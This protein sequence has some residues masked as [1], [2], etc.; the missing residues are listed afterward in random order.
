MT[1]ILVISNDKIFLN[2]KKVYSDYN[3][4]INVIEAI[5]NDFNILL[6]SR[7]SN[8]KNDFSAK[9]NNKISRI[10]LN[11]LFNLKK[12]KFKIFMIS[13]TPR[14]ILFYA[15]IKLF[16]KNLDGYVFLRSNGHKEYQKKI[17]KFGYIFYDIMQKYAEKNLKVISVSKKIKC[18]NINFLL[19]PSELNKTWFQKIRKVSL[20]FPKLLYFGRFRKEKGVYSLINLSKKFK[21]NYQL[22][23]AGDSSVNHPNNTKIDFL[24]KISKIKKIIDLYNSHNI[25]I[26]PSFT[27]GA[28]KVVLE[29]LARKR[30]VIVFKDIKHVKLN[31]EGIF[32]CD[33]NSISLEKCINFIIKNYKKIQTNMKKNNLPT[34]I[35]FQKKLLNILHE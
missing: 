4:T 31:F 1:K 9:I 29:S 25:F 13:I 19:N 15:L 8:I 17:G 14:N 6:I 30:P 2:S 3:D 28:P 22:T 34:K 23:I 33:R 35:S 7:I 12:E 20:D 11:S 21:F 26:L 32:V 16:I 18:S 27:E 5:D 24:G 10:N